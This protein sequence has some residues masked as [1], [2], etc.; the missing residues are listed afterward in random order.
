MTDRII[1]ARFHLRFIK[2]SIIQV[3]APTNDADEEAKDDFYEQ[4]QKVI[5]GVPRHD[6]LI[7]MGNWSAKVRGRKKGGNGIVGDHALEGIRND[8]GRYRNQIDH[9]AVNAR[10]RRSASD[11]RRP[12]LTG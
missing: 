1:M 12:Q 2:T 5:D 11:V 9:L 10:F 7:I 3:H 8:S 4:L 6:M